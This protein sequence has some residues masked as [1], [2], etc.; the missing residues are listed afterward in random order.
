[1]KTSEAFFYYRERVGAHLETFGFPIRR[2]SL[3][4]FE[5]DATE[6]VC[7]DVYGDGG[8]IRLAC[9]EE[10]R[11]LSWRGHPII[12]EEAS[13]WSEGGEQRVVV[14]VRAN[15]LDGFCWLESGYADLEFFDL[16]ASLPS[17][18]VYF[19]R[20]WVLPEMRS[21]GIGR[22][23]L[24]QAAIHARQLGFLR[25]LIACDPRNTKMRHLSTKLGWAYLQRVNYFRIGP[26]L[27][28][29]IRP[30]DGPSYRY[31]SQA[32]AEADLFFRRSS[33]GAP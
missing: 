3:L 5:R 31:S 24:R 10:F 25:F 29:S 15:Q 33:A 19:S 30:S 22:M 12:T 17:K 27:R 14:A 11:S 32:H 20:V 7:S 6:D 28:Y 21:S 26:F 2:R 8:A 4:F 9:R 18:V 1:M 13:T 16:M 23:L